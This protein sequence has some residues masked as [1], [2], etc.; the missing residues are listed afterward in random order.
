MLA[1]LRVTFET[2]LI[3]NA[4][5][6]AVADSTVIRNE[7]VSA[8]DRTRTPGSLPASGEK[9]A[10]EERTHDQHDRE[11]GKTPSPHPGRLDSH[12]RAQ[13]Q[14]R[15]RVPAPRHLPYLDRQILVASG[16]DDPQLDIRN[17]NDLTR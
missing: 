9:G 7:T 12:A 2:A 10:Q 5:E 4:F 15:T 6:F 1:D 3:P 8:R 11:P 13:R 17:S 16:F 14:L